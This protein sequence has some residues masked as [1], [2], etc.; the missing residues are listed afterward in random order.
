MIICLISYINGRDI[1]NLI[2][3]GSK[4]K[5]SNEIFIALLNFQMMRS[6]LT[7]LLSF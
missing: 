5:P 3:T 7:V 1:W 6:A 2:W 4:L